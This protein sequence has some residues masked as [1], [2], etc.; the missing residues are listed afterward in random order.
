MMR[1]TLDLV[2]VLFFKFS[3]VH[4]YLYSWLMSALYMLRYKRKIY[5]DG[6]C[7]RVGNINSI[8]FGNNFIAG[9]GFWV[10][11]IGESAEILFGD[12]VCISDWTHIA[13]VNKIVISSGC[14]IG[15]KVHITDHSHG[16][17]SN[18]DTVAHI[19]PKHRE[20]V[21]KGDVYIGRN[22]WIG[23]GVVITSGVSIGDGSIVAA[24]A[25]VTK[26]F[27]PY[28]IIAGVPA[29]CIKQIRSN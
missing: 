20:L 18:L 5:I 26:S 22:V 24:N 19:P 14:L 6:R 21:C 17:T 15:S 4:Y 1:K 7:L 10:D 16:I 29:R 3:K 23:D 12:D 8:V 28:S 25:V 2:F 27:P 11:A 13:S 9:Q